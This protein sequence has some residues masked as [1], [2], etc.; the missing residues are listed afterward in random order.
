ISKGEI[1]SLE[2]YEILSLDLTAL[3][4]D[5]GYA[6]GTFEGKIKALLAYL[7]E[8]KK[9]ILFIDEVHRITE[10]HSYG[11]QTSPVTLA[12]ILKP[13][14]A[15]GLTCIGAT[16]HEEYD[17]QIKNELALHRRFENKINVP[18]M[19]K[20]ETLE[21]LM[22]TKKDRFEDSYGVSIE[23]NALQTV[24]DLTSGIQDQEFPDKA[25]SLIHTV[26]S[27]AAK[28]KKQ[29]I[30]AEDVNRSFKKNSSG[31]EKQLSYF[32]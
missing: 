10:A 15:K 2:G 31:L 20:K 4:S 5:T 19:T 25:I 30:T 12:N 16:T 3:S 27:S 1:P 23:D 28:L 24:V 32:S 8:N 29:Q 13:D 17:Q 18:A 26:C 14:L 7:E 22:Q 11:V 9:T 6:I 21:L